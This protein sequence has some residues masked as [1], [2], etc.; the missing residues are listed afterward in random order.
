MAFMEFLIQELYVHRGRKTTLNF[1]GSNLHDLN[2]ISGDQVSCT[3]INI[4]SD[5]F[6]TTED[7]Y[8][9]TVSNPRGWFTTSNNFDNVVGFYNVRCYNCTAIGCTIGFQQT[10]YGVWENCVIE[11]CDIG[12]KFGA[13]S[14]ANLLRGYYCNNLIVANYNNNISNIRGDSVFESFCIITG[15]GNVISNVVADY[16]GEYLFEISVGGN[17]INGVS[18]PRFGVNHIAYTEEQLN[19]LVYGQYQP[20]HYMILFAQICVGLST[21]ITNLTRCGGVYHADNDL[22]GVNGLLK[23]KGGYGIRNVEPINF[24]LIPSS[25]FY[26][27]NLG[28]QAERYK[29]IPQFDINDFK[30]VLDM[31]NQFI[32]VKEMGDAAA[33]RHWQLCKLF[34]QRRPSLTGKHIHAL[35]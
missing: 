18:G 1:S 25:F 9:Q 22:Y 19:N 28:T 23:Y 4:V 33:L 34:F 35:I 6:S 14:Q 30:K 10:A 15:S 26:K 5:A 13:D 2:L 29:D 7:R 32:S 24:G 21:S 11:N 8:N 16:V 20:S 3:D 17:S 31:D 12:F 27:R